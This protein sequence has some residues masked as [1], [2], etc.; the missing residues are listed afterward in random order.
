MCLTLSLSCFLALSLSRLAS[1]LLSCCA[2]TRKH[3]HT[4]TRTHTSIQTHTHTHLPP[5]FLTYTHTLSF[6]VSLSHTHKQWRACTWMQHGIP[7]CMCKCVAMYCSVLQ[8]VAVCYSVLQCIAVCCSVL[9]CVATHEC[10][11]GFLAEDVMSSI[12]HVPHT[13]ESWNTFEWAHLND[14]MGHVAMMNLCHMQIAHGI[15]RWRCYVMS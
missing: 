7:R 9:Q 6:S 13:N 1:L 3:T 5:L 15:P 14:R 4:H 2:R 12:R 10:C 11:I 8:C